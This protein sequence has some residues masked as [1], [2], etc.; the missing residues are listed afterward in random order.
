MYLFVLFFT[1]LYATY[2]GLPSYFITVSWLI[3]SGIYF[4]LSILLKNI[5]Y[6]W[7]AMANLLVSALYLFLIDTAKIELIYRILAFLLFAIISIFISTYYVKK[8][9]KKDIDTINEKNDTTKY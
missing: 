4:G 8:L 9:K 7:M 5:K 3:I 2:K 6:R 1:L